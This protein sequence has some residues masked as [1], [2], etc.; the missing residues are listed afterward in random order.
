[1]QVCGDDVR[2]RLHDGHPAACVGDAPFAHV[3]VF[4]AHVNVGSSLHQFQSSTAGLWL[5]RVS[6]AALMF[7]GLRLLSAAQM[8]SSDARRTFRR[9]RG[10]FPEQNSCG[11]W[12]V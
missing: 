9:G 5:E 6:G 7:F 2:E 8:K 12:V 11:V 10:I 4:N 3:N 1:M